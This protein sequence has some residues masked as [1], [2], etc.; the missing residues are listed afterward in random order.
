MKMIKISIRLKIIII[1]T[2]H[3]IKNDNADRNGK[4]NND[5]ND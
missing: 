3:T 1:Q 5:N 2:K 4:I